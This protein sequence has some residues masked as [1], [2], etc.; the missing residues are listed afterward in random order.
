MTDREINEK[1]S[2]WLGRECSCVTELDSD[3]IVQG[4]PQYTT[5]WGGCP[6]HSD[7]GHPAP[8]TTSDLCAV[9]LLPV[10]VERGYWIELKH[11]N[12]P[13]WRLDIGEYA[14]TE[15]LFGP[16]KPTIAQAI[17]ATL[18]QLIESI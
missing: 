4:I 12:I 10:L 14:P 11:Y 16:Q 18:I 9:E 13:R 7:G 5:Y 3:N 6:M 8:Y 2:K 15:T 17:T 1:I